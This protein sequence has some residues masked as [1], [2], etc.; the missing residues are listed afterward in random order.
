MT[1]G[2]PLK[3]ELS[4]TEEIPVNDSGVGKRIT[5]AGVRAGMAVASHTHPLS[6]LQQSGASSGQTPVWNGTDWAPATPSGG[7]AWG[8]ITGTLS[9]QTDLQTALNG[10]A[11]SSHTHAQ[12]QVT[13]LVTDLAAKAALT[14]VVRTDAAQT[15][16]NAQ[17]RRAA[18]NSGMLV[19]LYTELIP[20]GAD[21]LDPTQLGYLPLFS[22]PPGMAFNAMSWGLAMTGVDASFEVDNNY[23]IGE[24]N[25]VEIQSRDPSEE[26][27]NDDYT[28]TTVN[29]TIGGATPMLLN[30]NNDFVLQ[31]SKDYRAFFGEFWFNDEYSP[32]LILT[33]LQSW[34][35]GVW[36]S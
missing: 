10:K 33:G 12:N 15:L 14:Q 24:W 35:R 27:W 28:A 23:V 34:I 30:H 1:S 32:S 3:T 13:N 29:L 16:S 22:I 31:G 25:I 4:G 17:R 26:N 7:G 36:L 19:T 20:Y 6:A 5:V 21:P 9:A 8:S 2:K 18:I 11:A